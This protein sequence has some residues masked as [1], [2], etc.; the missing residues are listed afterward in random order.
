LIGEQSEDIL[1]DNASERSE[2]DDDQQHSRGAECR[3]Q[4][5]QIANG[6]SFERARRIG[7]RPE[8]SVAILFV[9]DMDPFDL[10]MATHRVG[11]PVQAI[12]DDPID[13]LDS[14]QR[15]LRRIDLQPSS[16][17][18]SSSWRRS[19]EPRL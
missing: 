13:S 15:G 8:G 5:S 9:P 7:H 6:L 19:Q 18:R 11:Q 4:F 1:A 16:S 17:D 2:D 3:H 12:P 10:A 14:P